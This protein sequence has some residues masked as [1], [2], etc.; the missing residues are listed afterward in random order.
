MQKMVEAKA[1]D[2]KP[3]W[4]TDWFAKFDN[5]TYA[6]WT[7][8]AWGPTLMISSMKES[9]GKWRAASL[10]QWKAGDN[11]VSNWGGS[12]FAAM[13]TTQHLKEAT[14]LATFLGGDPEVGK[15]WNQKGF[16]FPVQKALLADKELMGHKYDFYGGQAVNEIFAEAE[17]HVDPSFEFAP[18]QDYVNS[19]LQDELAAALSGKGTLAEAFDRVQDTIV[20]YATDQGYT[21]V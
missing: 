6:S 8:A 10:P 16:L 2:T 3:E 9:V 4:T 1:I 15:Y 12:T 5:G 21:V 17:N 11:V 20:G 19:Q 13:S 18:F 14:T 7:T